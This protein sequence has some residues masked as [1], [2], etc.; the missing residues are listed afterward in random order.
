[1]GIR[2][3]LAIGC[4]LHVSF[5][6]TGYY[7]EEIGVDFT[8]RCGDCWCVPEGG[9]IDGTCPDFPDGIWQSFPD[10]WGRQLSTFTLTSDPLTLH[11]KTGATG[12][13]PFFDAVGPQTYPGSTSPQCERPFFPTDNVDSVVCAFKY[14]EDQACSGREYDMSSYA[15][16]ESAVTAGAHVTHSG[17]CGVCSNAQ[18]LGVRMSRFGELQAQSI[19]CATAHAISRDFPALIQCFENLGF[20]DQCSL[21]WAHFGATNLLCAALCLPDPDSLVIELHEAAPTCALLPC[22][23]CSS[24]QFEGDFNILAGRSRSMQNSG[25]NDVIPLSCD[26]FYLI[27]DHD[28]CVGAAPALSPAPASGPAPSTPTMS[29]TISS[30]ATEWGPSFHS[31]MML[32]SPIL[33]LIVG[34]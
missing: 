8:S 6:E 5:G 29:P 26:S 21:L 24:S 27:E 10:D 16:A 9:T 33:L 13:Y 19:F 17:A 23:N 32:V 14:A 1:M 30:A 15:S 34:V 20:T 3:I 12:C 22:L 18:D 28:P 7:S 4:L 25:F 11:T 2:F 31:I